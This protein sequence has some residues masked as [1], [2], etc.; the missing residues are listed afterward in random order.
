MGER[1]HPHTHPLH[2]PRDPPGSSENSWKT[3]AV[4][5]KFNLYHLSYVPFSPC[6][7]ASN[8]E[9]DHHRAPLSACHPPTYNQPRVLLTLPPKELTH[10]ATSPRRLHI[11]LHG[12][13][14]G[15]VSAS[16]QSIAV[17]PVIP[18]GPVRR[19]SACVYGRILRHQQGT[20]QSHCSGTAGKKE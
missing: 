20:V 1:S 16:G 3:R 11:S 15:C 6:T 9:A 7:Q 10:Q 18:P 8:R 12:P 4:Q 2:S 13:N 19:A 17:V 14:H 5:R